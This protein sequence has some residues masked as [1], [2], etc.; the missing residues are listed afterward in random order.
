M[1]RPKQ[2]GLLRPEDYAWIDYVR[3]RDKKHQPLS[4]SDRQRLDRLRDRIQ[5]V[6]EQLSY[7]AQTLPE[8][9]QRQIFTP[10]KICPL[11]YHWLGRHLKREERL[12]R[13]YQF[14]R[15]FFEWSLT[16]Y[17]EKL[18]GVTGHFLWG[19][20]LEISEIIQAVIRERGYSA[21][22]VDEK[23][24]VEEIRSK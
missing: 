12:E 19:K 13:H 6:F 15:M 1:P 17:Q 20:F 2:F 11:I 14:A 10:A 16:L 22:T 23:L 18:D 4:N 8:S 3:N 7:L 5:E 24:V 9:Q 21:K